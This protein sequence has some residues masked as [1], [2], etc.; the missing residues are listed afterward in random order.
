MLSAIF[1]TKELR[2]RYCLVNEGSHSFTCYPHVHPRMEWAVAAFTPQLHSITALWLVLIFHPTEGRK[3]SW[4]EWQVKIPRWYASWTRHHPSTNRTWHRVT[5]LIET[6]MLPLSP[7][8]IM[9]CH[10]LSWPLTADHS[11]SA[12][13]YTFRKEN[14]DQLS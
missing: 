1:L 13:R 14:T 5:S 6:K 2:Y 11:C 7:A 8:A 3:L 4:I 12:G 10:C 9:A